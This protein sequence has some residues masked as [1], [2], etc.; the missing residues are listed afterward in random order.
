MRNSTRDWPWFSALHIWQK[1]LIGIVLGVAV[2][3]LLLL[4]NRLG[5][6]IVAGGVASLIIGVVIGFRVGANFFENPDPLPRIAWLVALAAIVSTV[7]IAVAALIS[8]RSW[9]LWFWTASECLGVIAW[10]LFVA[11]RLTHR[12]DAPP[13]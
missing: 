5:M 1:G 13:R 2:A 9:L 6:Y 4:P 11:A 12:S 3:I 7:A 8:R 10:M